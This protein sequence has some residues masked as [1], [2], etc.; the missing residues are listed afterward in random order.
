[1]SYYPNMF[2]PPESGTD[3]Y[4][5]KINNLGDV[6]IEALAKDAPVV[7]SSRG[8]T[9]LGNVGDPRILFDNLE[10]MLT[11]LKDSEGNS[12]SVIYP[13]EL[14]VFGVNSVEQLVGRL[15]A[16]GS[17]KAKQIWRATPIRLL[18]NGVRWDM[19]AEVYKT[20]EGDAV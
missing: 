12:P 2:K 3:S 13:H 19:E 20:T 11:H 6:V 1:M 10:L 18:P 9:I 15:N 14:W 16:K 17:S 5:L 4:L 8:M 7:A